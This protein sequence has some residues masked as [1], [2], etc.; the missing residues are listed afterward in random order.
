M[1]QHKVT[2]ETS[3]DSTQITIDGVLWMSVE[4]GLVTIRLANDGVYVARD[5]AVNGMTIAPFHPRLA[6]VAPE[7]RDAVRQELGL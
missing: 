3:G 1:S 2:T 7:H 6:Y 5:D 4:N